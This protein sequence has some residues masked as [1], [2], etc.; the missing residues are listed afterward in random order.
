MLAATPRSALFLRRLRYHPSMNRTWLFF[1]IVPLVAIPL[2]IYVFWHL[3]WTPLRISGLVLLIVGLVFLT[4]ARF[5]LGK[6]FSLTPQARQLVTH[7][8]YSR[9]R[10][11][12]YVFGAVLILG[13]FLFL[14]RPYYLLVLLI[15][16]PLQI[17]RA[18]AEARVLEERFGDEYRQYK[19]KTWF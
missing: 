17:A 14:D 5:Q 9:I 13:L 15:I 4:I 10:N 12:V 3:P 1:V 6:S 16:I 18:R 7:G 2:L 11:P 8:L 19:S